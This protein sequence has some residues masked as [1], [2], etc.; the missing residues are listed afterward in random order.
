M[1]RT[2]R[3]K[4]IIK[5]KSE[6]IKNLQIFLI[7]RNYRMIFMDDIHTEKHLHRDG[8]K[9]LN[10]FKIFEKQINHRF[11]TCFEDNESNRKYTYCRKLALE[12]KYI[13]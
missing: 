12:L 1:S 8:L 2:I 9:R 7:H 6:K 5:N 11:R 3:R 10:I 4:T 13:H